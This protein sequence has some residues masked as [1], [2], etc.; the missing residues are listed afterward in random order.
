MQAKNLKP[1][2]NPNYNRATL[3]D[4]AI[5]QQ[6][7]PDIWA[8]PPVKRG[9]APAPTP[10]PVE[11]PVETPAVTSSAAA[12]TEQLTNANGA[13]TQNNTGGQ[14][15]TTGSR[16]GDRDPDA[17]AAA[18][19]TV[20][21]S[22]PFSEPSG[23]PASAKYPTVVPGKV[24][25]QEELVAFQQAMSAA[26]MAAMQER[27]QTMYR[28]GKYSDTP[29]GAG[30]VSIPLE[31]GGYY[32]YRAEP[33]WQG[34]WSTSPN[35]G[36]NTGASVSVGSGSA[37]SGATSSGT[38]TSGTTSGAGNL[39]SLLEEWKSAA[40]AQANGQIDY[41]VFQAITEL[42][43]AL[44]DAQPAFRE[45]A[46]AVARDEAIALDNSALYAELRGDKGGIGQSQYNEIQAAAAQNRL[47]VQQAQTKLS[48]DTARQ[49]ADLRAQGEFEKADKLLEI[50]QTYL[51]QLISIEQWAAEFNFSKEQFEEAIRQWDA[52]Y[53][54]AVNQFKF[55]KETW[56][57]E[58]DYRANSDDVDL[59]LSMMSAGMALTDDQLKKIGLSRTA[60][61]EWRKTQQL[62]GAAG[63]GEV[64]ANQL[65]A[66]G[67]DAWYEY[68]A[69]AA[70]G[71]GQSVTDYLTENRD[72]LNITTGMVD[73]YAR[74]AQQKYDF[75]YGKPTGNTA[76][77]PNSV[78]RRLS[79]F[80]TPDS[81][82][83]YLLDIAGSY[84]LN[85]ADI[86]TLFDPIAAVKG[87]D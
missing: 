77:L 54:L 76:K 46:E 67:T 27:Q 87:W 74:G 80:E 7:L 33:V 75:L 34:Y 53:E 47:A 71:K 19:T 10:G 84:G 25:T 24:Y 41:A 68:V 42:E 22:S 69:V 48:T 56:K 51:S 29:S 5:L 58:F 8:T 35:A 39:T 66:L 50:T 60:Y 55:D 45:A 36:S 23:T 44:E 21:N 16:T 72:K 40:A 20:T 31:S 61:D 30:W 15:P 38:T 62:T 26:D 63:D 64:P 3:A 4:E 82:Y 85:M 9:A 73:Q 37:S 43:R 18:G 2:P 79:S 17:P 70:A 52:E 14:T 59:I 28:A 11:S 86:Q 6:P 57:Q 78:V 49:I 13:A 1:N 12:M 65:P 83:S 32:E 81:L